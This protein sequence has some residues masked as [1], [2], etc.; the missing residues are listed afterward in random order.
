MV[1]LTSQFLHQAP[2][3]RYD[4]HPAGQ[5][6]GSESPCSFVI[7]ISFSTIYCIRWRNCQVATLMVQLFVLEESPATGFSYI[8]L[9]QLVKLYFSLSCILPLHQNSGGSR[10]NKGLWMR[11]AA[12]LAHN[13]PSRATYFG[14]SEGKDLMNLLT[15]HLTAYSIFVLLF[16]MPPS[17]QISCW[18]GIAEYES[19]RT[20]PSLPFSVGSRHIS[21]VRHRN[22]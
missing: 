9:F 14:V 19:S 12:A 6:D 21:D 7:P 8:V 13:L 10:T 18:Q 4:L 1:R 5:A 15:C 17:C 22:L 20:R 2:N 3:H 16:I 11:Y